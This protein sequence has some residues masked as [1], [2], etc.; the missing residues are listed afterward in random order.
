MPSQWTARNTIVF[1]WGLFLVMLQAERWFLL[2]EAYAFERSTSAVLAQTLLTGLRADLIVASVGVLVA[3][4][5][6]LALWGLPALAT[7]T[8]LRPMPAERVGRLFT[9]A[10]CGLGIAFCLVL[11]V[12]MGYYGYSH[13]RLDFV[14]FEFLDD[15][16]AAGGTSS[17]AAIQ[18]GA[19]LHDASKWA[20]RVALFLALETFVVLLWWQVYRRMVA[21]RLD[22]LGSA[23]PRYARM[24]LVGGLVGGMM[25]FHPYGPW[26]VQRAGISSS[27]Y[28][29]LAQNPVWYGGEVA[30]AT[31]ASGLSGTVARLRRLMPM[32]EA[33]AR[34]RAAVAPGA[35]FADPRYP[36]VHTSGENAGITLPRRANVLLVFMEGL[37]RRYLGRSLDPA[38]DVDFGRW[39]IYETPQLRGGED[40]SRPGGIRVTPFLDRLRSDSLYFERFFSNGTQSARGLF[41]S[42]CSYY[43]RQG[44]A[45]MKTR[46]ALEYLCLPELLRRG[47]YETE[48]VVGQNRDRN[49]DHI[50]LFLARNGLHRLLDESDF[51]PDAEKLGLGVTD[52]ALFDFLRT[53]IEA[54]RQPGRPYFLA[55][56]TVGTHHPYEVPGRHPDV[57]AL[58]RHADRYVAALRQ[59]DLEFERF[60]SGLR[61][62]GLLRDTIVLILGDH[63][64]HHGSGRTETERWA[65]HFTIPLYV[66]VDPS[67]RTPATYR[68]RTVPVVA[69][70]VD[71]APT[72]LQLA[73]LSPKVSPFLGRD[74]SCLLA[75]ACLEDH[76]AFLTSVYD[77]VVGLADRDGIWFYSLRDG[78]VYHNTL[79]FNGPAMPR[80]ATDP[81]V[82]PV[83]QRILGLYVGSNVLLEENRIWSRTAFG[84]EAV[85]TE[86]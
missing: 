22:K 62:D 65:G 64:R 49:Y 86:P 84:V 2:P 28:Y 20:A 15:L 78:R 27:T 71:L 35:D 66:W 68:P 31:F 32:E 38:S 54:L 67:L 46:Y 21:P 39:F 3:G 80:A 56:M 59:L 60:F 79:D 23:A 30:L 61:E 57:R 11:L 81:Q 40:A 4:G 34:T 37:D 12:D 73:G 24:L 43:P 14:F 70:Q 74:L 36:L 26:S 19:E 76:F 25:G 75:G 1:W 85:T 29:A 5:L 48:M 18:T 41:A 50:G 47:G 13:R 55:T 42:L 83:Y 51:P 9:G 7:G 63:G 53:R 45:V 10:A 44:T 8:P 77:D 72:I 6:A 82:R 58:Q 17:Q 33:V 52:G 16:L 69:S